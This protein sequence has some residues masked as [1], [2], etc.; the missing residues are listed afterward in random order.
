[1]FGESVYSEC[2]TVELVSSMY[3]PVGSLHKTAPLENWSA[4]T[5]YHLLL[6]NPLW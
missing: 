4:R 1:M 2:A 6:F 5:T 3:S